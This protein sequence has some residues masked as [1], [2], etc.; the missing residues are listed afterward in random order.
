MWPTLDAMSSAVDLRHFTVELPDGRTLQAYEAGAES[1]PVAIFHHGTPVSGLLNPAW[2]AAARDRG[3]RLIGFDRAGYGGSSRHEGRTVADVAA[4]VAALADH[5]GADRFFTWGESGGGP[6]TLACAAL[7]GK[8]VRAAVTFA[9]VAPYDVDG[10]DFLDG[11]GQDNIDE[12]GAAL[13]GEQALRPYLD[14]QAQGIR[15][16]T[17]E[18]LKDALDSLLPEVDKAVLTGDEAAYLH[19]A[20]VHGLEPGVDGWLDDDIAFTRAWGFDLGAIEVPLRIV[21]GDQDL[22]VPFAHGK[23]LAQATKG[24]E[25]QLMPGEGHLSIHSDIGPTFDWLLQH[26]H[27][28]P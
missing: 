12:F 15:D 2:L 25:V 7:L 28:H 10:L 18:T 23:W 17:P 4:D 22:M 14:E 13:E 20:M 11:M 1:G 24:A 16:A 19:G 5:V 27:P 9:S 6:H 21:Q 3:L 8:R 26:G